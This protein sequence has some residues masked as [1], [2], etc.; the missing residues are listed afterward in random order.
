[1]SKDSIREILQ[2]HH[3]IVTEGLAE[4]AIR[5]LESLINRE[6]LD[7]IEEAFAKFCDTHVPEGMVLTVIK[8]GEGLRLGLPEI[9]LNRS[10]QLNKELEDKV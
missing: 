7:A 8:K 9:E 5:E 4:E 6:R 3:L 10:A 1:M 2:K